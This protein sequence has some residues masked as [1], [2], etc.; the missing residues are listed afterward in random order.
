MEQE[1]TLHDS[2][3]PEAEQNTEQEPAEYQQNA[4]QEQPPLEYQQSTEQPTPPPRRCARCGATLYG[5]YCSTCG[6]PEGGYAPYVPPTKKR[7]HTALWVTL[8]VLFFTTLC[9]GGL[10]LALLFVQPREEANNF[11][12]DFYYDQPPYG[13]FDFDFGYTN[14]TTYLRVDAMGT[15]RGSGTEEFPAPEGKEYLIVNLRITNLFGDIIA[16]DSAN[17][18]LSCGKGNLVPVQY[19]NIDAAT[20]LGYGRLLP[21]GEVEGS[22]VFLIPKGDLNLE[23]FLYDYESTIRFP[24]L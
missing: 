23:L 7:K 22:I 14:E 16:Y 13:D 8:G 11:G 1:E 3:A 5:D 10:C 2:Q 4:E 9:L 6:L 12:E 24:L 18:E 19:T 21:E 15:K 17:F 20:A